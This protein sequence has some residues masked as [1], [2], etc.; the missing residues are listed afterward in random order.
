[1]INKQVHS[2]IEYYIT[3]KNMKA[4][5]TG[6]TE[7]LRHFD[8]HIIKLEMD[9]GLKSFDD[10]SVIHLPTPEKLKMTLD[11]AMEKRRS[12]RDFQNYKITLGEL[13]TLLFYS[14]GYKMSEHNGRKHVPSSGG[15]CT[16]ELF[17]IILNSDEVAPGLYYFS[18]K[19]YILRCIKKGDYRDWVKNDAMYQEEW[20]NASALV[21]L[22]CD[23]ARLYQKYGYRTL[24]LCLLDAGHVAQNLYLTC[25]A[26][27]MKIC[28]VLGYVENEVEEAFDLTGNTPTFSSLVIGR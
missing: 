10:R 17:L 13:S 27:D 3:S 11:D 25:A 6:K 5:F 1:M 8:P 15:F 22:A 9:Q 24:R 28:E 18:A 20:A 26:M 21:F 2:D 23:Y 4:L 14:A 16:T 7:H 19:D 12:R